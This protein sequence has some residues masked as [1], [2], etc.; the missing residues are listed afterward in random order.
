MNG[1]DTASQR[2]DRWVP[3][4]L[5]AL[6]TIAFWPALSGDFL[7][8]DVESVVRNAF[9]A[10]DLSLGRLFEAEPLGR[11]RPLTLVAWKAGHLVGGGSKIGFHAVSLLVHLAASSVAFLLARRLTGDV[12]TAFFTAALFAVHP[13][14]SESVA[15]IGSLDVVLAGLFGL[16][17][18][19]AHVRWR[20]SGS[21]GLPVTSGVAFALALC[22]SEWAVAVLPL[23]AALDFG[24][25]PASDVSKRFTW[26]AYL[27]LLLALAAV[28]AGRA[29]AYG[30]AWAGFDRSVFVYE[31]GPARTAWLRVE[32]IGGLVQLVLWPFELLPSRPFVPA[33]EAFT[34]AT[35]APL[36]WLAALA[37][38]IAWTIKRDTRPLVAAL[39]WLPVAVLPVALRL[40]TLGPEPISD[41]LAYLAV[42]GGTFG[43]TLLAFRLPRA[44]ALATLGGLTLLSTFATHRQTGIWRNDE[45]VLRAAGPRHNTSPA[46]A[47]RLGQGLLERYRAEAD[48]ELL[49]EAFL[50][51]QKALDLLLAAREDAAILATR[52]DHI[53]ANLG[54]AWCLWYEALLQ[55]P[56]EYQTAAGVFEQIVDR[57]PEATEAWVGLAITQTAQGR[58]PE[59]ERSLR[60]ALETDPHSAR[61]L[62]NLGQV[63][64]RRERWT[65]AAEAFRQAQAERPGHL[66]DLL[67]EARSW[68]EAGEVERARAALSV[69]RARH[70]KSPEPL[71]VEATLVAGEARGADALELVEDALELDP[72]NGDALLLKGKLHAARQEYQV[73]AQAFQR[74]CERLP[75]SFEAH[76][77]AASLLM[78]LSGNDAALPYLA[79]AY[80]LRGDDEAGRLLAST[81]RATEIRSALI[82]YELASED[83]RRGDDE[84]ALEWVEAAIGLR[85]DRIDAY[86]LKGGILD[87]LG[88]AEE[89]V[90]VLTY[91]CETDPENLRAHMLLGNL[92]ADRN[93][94]GAVFHL[95]RALAL[96]S[97]ADVPPATKQSMRQA[98][99][100]RLDSLRE[101]L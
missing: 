15:W 4:A 87:R 37:L 64:V 7:R 78:S 3:F 62:H 1:Q 5:L 38:A 42:F 32:M 12:L 26:R 27:P 53:H 92:L 21:P 23:A 56:H 94:E 43:L 100:N 61:A 91:A 58:L 73:A 16:L 24:R 2:R 65:D 19:H 30:D 95:E 17:A 90:E 82:L 34:G 31:V 80:R 14:Q 28:Y 44:A 49:S 54:F 20:D 52:E 47:I 33:P 60:T 13:V 22:A 10:G 75:D 74:A 45:T 93:R 8:D 46:V 98:L 96:A 29:V 59:A 70:P 6:T 99:Q 41:R 67:G 71:V 85:P 77:N 18:L 36:A 66:D 97:T 11:W 9:V 63:F 48:P 39:I 72:D 83:A 55:E 40:R 84:S 25:P 88:K 79:R 68:V 51:F 76:Y 86:L 50:E 69:A 81:L 57:Y 89:A 35:L 101:N